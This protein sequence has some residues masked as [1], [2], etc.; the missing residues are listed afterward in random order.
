M[1]A[2][3]QPRTAG[4][5]LRRFHHK[6]PPRLDTPGTQ[7]NSLPLRSAPP[8]RGPQYNRAAHRA[9]TTPRHPPRDHR[10]P[11]P[12]ILSRLSFSRVLLIFSD[13]LLVFSSCVSPRGNT[14]RWE[15]GGKCARCFPAN[16]AVNFVARN[17]KSIALLS[18]DFEFGRK[19][20]KG[21]KC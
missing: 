9:N 18:E 15:E 4:S 19:K 11:L 10:H 6:P 3:A 16:P 5:H 2:D 1:A 13:S 21:E 20:R 7:Y 14:I 12:P 17:S 8:P